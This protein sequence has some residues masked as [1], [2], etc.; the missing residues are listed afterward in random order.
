MNKTNIALIFS[1]RANSLARS[2]GQVKL[3]LGK[4]CILGRHSDLSIIVRLFSLGKPPRKQ[5]L[6]GWQIWM[7]T[8]NEDQQLHDITFIVSYY[9]RTRIEFLM[10]YN[11]MYIIIRGEG[12]YINFV[13]MLMI[14]FY[15]CTCSLMCRML[16]GHLENLE[17]FYS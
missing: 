12:G 10:K 11:H 5:P 3:D 14:Q 16:P 15:T 9:S 7:S 17:W 8:S 13:F 1:L 6:L 2:R 4:D